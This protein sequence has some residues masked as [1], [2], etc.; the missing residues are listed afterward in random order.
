MVRIC[1]RLTQVDY[2]QSSCWK[3]CNIRGI[4]AFFPFISPHNSWNYKALF[5][6]SL[7]ICHWR[8]GVYLEKNLCSMNT[9]HDHYKKSKGGDVWCFGSL[10][11]F[12]C[13]CGISALMLEVFISLEVQS[14][15]IENAIFLRLESW[16]DTDIT[17]GE[18]LKSLS[19]CIYCKFRGQETLARL[20]VRVPLLVP[21]L[22]NELQETGSIQTPKKKSIDI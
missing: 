19:L 17:W 15:S 18:Q 21:S 4:W 7:A 9:L 16:S 22:P 20:Q 10:V 6:F 1:H 3:N 11:V 14:L 12:F 2:K 13:L 5:L 8:E